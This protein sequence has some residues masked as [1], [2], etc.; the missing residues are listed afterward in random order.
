MPHCPNCSAPRV[1]EVQLVPHAIAELEVEEEGMDGMEWGTVILGVCG[2]D[3]GER[4]IEAGRWGWVEEW[5]GVQW[6]E[7]GGRGVGVVR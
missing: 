7:E 4:G 2:S 5:V 6:E 1:F 3:C